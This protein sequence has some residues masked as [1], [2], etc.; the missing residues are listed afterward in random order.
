MMEQ[1]KTVPALEPTATVYPKA[2]APPATADP[3]SKASAEEWAQD[4]GR[5]LGLIDNTANTVMMP[6]IQVRLFCTYLQ[7]PFVFL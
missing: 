6:L 5:P 1:A 7:K 2:S 3:S 4:L